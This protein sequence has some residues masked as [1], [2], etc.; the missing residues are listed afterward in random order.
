MIQGGLRP[1][2]SKRGSIARYFAPVQRNR[3]ETLEELY[4]W[5]DFELYDLESDRNETQNLAA[6]REQNGELLLA[7]NAKLNALIEAEIG[8]DDGGEMPEV[9]GIDWFVERIDL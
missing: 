7:M 8:A 5:N 4:R 3:P 9:E 6:N 2:L 1:D